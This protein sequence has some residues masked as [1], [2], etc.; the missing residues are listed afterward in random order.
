MA[1]VST[2]ADTSGTFSALPP[3]RYRRTSKK[4]TENEILQNRSAATAQQQYEN[5][6]Q[7]ACQ[8]SSLEGLKTLII[9]VTAVV[10]LITYN[11]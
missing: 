9:K 1:C 7:E 2:D 5:H 4:N 3:W 11:A 6:F 8:H 10:A